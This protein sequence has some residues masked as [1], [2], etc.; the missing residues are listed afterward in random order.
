MG[1]PKLLTFDTKILK[2]TKSKKCHKNKILWWQS[3]I[4]NNHRKMFLIKLLTKIDFW[5]RILLFQSHPSSNNIKILAVNKLAMSQRSKS[6][7]H[8]DH[9]SHFSVPG[10]PI[11]GHQW[12]DL[13]LSCLELFF[14]VP[15]ESYSVPNDLIRFFN[16]GSFFRFFNFD[17]LTIFRYFWI[18]EEL[19]FG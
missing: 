8:T 3:Q 15:C 12:I 6:G 18:Y 16:F 10:R 4:V 2:L 19:I 17:V 13:D 9:L 14:W 1:D 7:K 11:R 5:E